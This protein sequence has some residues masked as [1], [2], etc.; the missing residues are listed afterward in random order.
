MKEFAAWQKLDDYPLVLKENCSKL[1]ELNGLVPSLIAEPV[2]MTRIFPHFSFEQLGDKFYRKTA[3]EMKRKHNQYV[4]SLNDEFF[5]EEFVDMLYELFLSKRT[6]R[7]ITCRGGYLDR[8]LVI[9][10]NRFHLRFCNSV[11]RDILL[12]TFSE[13]CSTPYGQVELSKMLERAQELGESGRFDDQFFI[14]C[15]S[16]CP[17]IE[18]HSRGHIGRIQFTTN[19]F[20]RFDGKRF[21]P[22][23]KKIMNSCWVRLCKNHAKLDCAYVDM[24]NSDGHCTFL[25]LLPHCSLIA[26]RTRLNWSCCLVLS[27]AIL[28]YY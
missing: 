15:L 24:S 12:K 19:K 8:G 6:P 25:W 10:A 13:F 21:D 23:L 4:H 22:P 1:M 16:E 3:C 11:A 2:K 17:M 9:T 26:T 28:L 20:W 27:L 18:L 7:R 5:K 14:W